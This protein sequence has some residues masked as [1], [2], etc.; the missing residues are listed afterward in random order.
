[1]KITIDAGKRTEIQK[2]MIGLFFED[3]NYAADGGLY[4][5]MLENRCFEFMK[6]TGDAKDYQTVYD[7]SYAWSL[8]PAGARGTARPVTG[9]P[10]SEEN[11]HYM[12]LR[13]EQAGE[14]IQNKAYE[15]IYLKKDMEYKLLFWARCVKFTGDFEIF[16]EKDN[17]RYAQVKISALEGQEETCNHFRR[18]E[19]VM[20]AEK[21]VERGSFVLTLSV[22]GTV[23]L[24]FVSLFPGDAVCGIFRRDLFEMLKE[25]QPGFLRFPG[26]CIDRKSG[27]AGM[28]RP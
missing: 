19:A 22:P 13:T 24:D 23:E 1:M 3:I 6:A 2:G 8:Y 26:G 14:G 4:A 11:P 9:S 18:F 28:P 7:G 10:H 21:D 12:R 15:G 16:V 25:L 17:K 27:S 5:E 20:R